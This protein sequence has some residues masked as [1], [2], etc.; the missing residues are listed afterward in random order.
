[1][2]FNLLLFLI[3]KRAEAYTL[4][5]VVGVTVFNPGRPGWFNIKKLSNVIHNINKLKK[6]HDPINAEKTM[7]KVQ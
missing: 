7:N 3:I 6:L 2:F 4:V 1:M 5:F